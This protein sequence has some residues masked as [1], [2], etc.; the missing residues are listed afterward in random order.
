M[1]NPRPVIIDCD[2]GVDDTL[3]LALALASPELDVLAVTTVAGNASIETTSINATSVLA[4][5]GRSDVPVGVGARRALVHAYDHGL[6][7]P[8][9]IDGL[10]GAAVALAEVPPDAQHAVYLLRDILAA[11]EPSS[12]TIA[13]TGPL[14]NIALLASLHPELLSRIEQVVVMGGSAGRGNI[15]PVAEFNVWTDPESAQRVLTDPGLDIVLVG[16]DVTRQATLTPAHL[17]I[18]RQR[19]TLGALLADMVE[20]YRDRTEAGWA[21]HDAVTIAAIVEPE[22]VRMV[23][24]LV[25]VDTGTG[26]TRGQTI[27]EFV[28]AEL[29]RV[30]GTGRYSDA[31]LVQFAEGIDVE[32]FRRL[33]LDRVGRQPTRLPG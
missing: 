24:A 31:G 32:G 29:A 12:V 20:G 18:V 15:T 5:C 6:P 11:S 16:L 21:I 13:A 14:T 30:A 25:E 2:P 3:C 8:H 10:G 33:M 7:P 9:G 27:C 28:G 23:P 4:A 19:S 26:A 22:L 1:V 17:A